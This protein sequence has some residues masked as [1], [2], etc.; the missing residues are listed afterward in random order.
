[1]AQRHNGAETQRH[2][3]AMAQRLKGTK[4]HQEAGINDKLLVKLG[5]S[6]YLAGRVVF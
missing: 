6:A 3:G 5:V 4:F 1:M 2:R